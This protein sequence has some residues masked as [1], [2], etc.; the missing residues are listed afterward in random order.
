MGTWGPWVIGVLVLGPLGQ[1]AGI[2]AVKHAEASVLAPYTYTRMI[3]SGLVG[4]LIF[5]EHYSNP[6]LL[7]TATVI[8]SCILVSFD[9]LK[10]VRKL[11]PTTGINANEAASRQVITASGR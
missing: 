8:S 3:L 1:F 6:M 9:Q 7:G 10:D 5:H 2:H 11:G 4:I